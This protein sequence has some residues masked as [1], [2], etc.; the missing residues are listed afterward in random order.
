MIL[1]FLLTLAALIPFYALG[2]FPTGVLVAARRGVDLTVTGSKN[3][4]AT[5]V[6]RSVGKAAAIIT[7]L[8]DALKGFIAPCV[9]WFLTQD[10]R[11]AELCAIAVVAGHCFSIPGFLKGGRGVATG[12][13]VLLFLEPAA[14]G[15]ALG[16]FAFVFLTW[17][18]VSLASVCAALSAPLYCFLSAAPDSRS[19][20]LGGIALLIAIRHRAN[21]NRL[22]TGTEP[23]LAVS[24]RNKSV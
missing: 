15:V 8:G 21:L 24:T 11:F 6:L 19:F 12:L 22:A 14:A 23:K 10:G 20:T 4:G 2:C 1:N 9:G 3:V 7:L 13:G 16:I 17:R 5:N 18:Y